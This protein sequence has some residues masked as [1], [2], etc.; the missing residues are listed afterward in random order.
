MILQEWRCPKCNRILARHQLAAGS[1]VEVICRSCGTAV[2][3]QVVDIKQ[4]EPVIQPID[5]GEN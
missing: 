3:L 1:T 5:K 2:T 4:D